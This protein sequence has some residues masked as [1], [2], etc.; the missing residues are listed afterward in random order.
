MRPRKIIPTWKHVQIIQ[1]LFYRG[2]N[3]R[4]IGLRIIPAR[5]FSALGLSC[6]VTSRRCSNF[7]L[8]AAPPLTGCLLWIAVRLDLNA[9]HALIASLKS[10]N[11]RVLYSFTLTKWAVL[12]HAS[13]FRLVTIKIS[14]KS[15]R[16]QSARGYICEFFFLF[17]VQK[18][19][20]VSVFAEFGLLVRT[21][22]GIPILMCTLIVSLYYQVNAVLW[23]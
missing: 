3:A 9:K 18:K 2:M 12:I 21:S 22:R 20:L 14:N 13:I 6:P 16:K 11:P 10:T 15:Q 8:L 19:L 23:L 17:F 4:S 7:R 5:P 1:L